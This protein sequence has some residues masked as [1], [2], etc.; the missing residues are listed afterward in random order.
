[1]IAPVSDRNAMR[2]CP[3]LLGV[4]P[5][6]QSYPHVG[7]DVAP[8]CPGMGLRIGELETPIIIFPPQLLFFTSAEKYVGS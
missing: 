8:R 6:S 7:T 5:P 2:L 4:A 1:M 3:E